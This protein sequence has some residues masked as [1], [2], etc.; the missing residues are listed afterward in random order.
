MTP[1][2]SLQHLSRSPIHTLRCYQLFV[3]T[4]T[5][6]LVEG[7]TWGS[8]LGSRTLQRAGCGGQRSGVKKG[9]PAR[10]DQDQR[11]DVT[12]QRL[13]VLAIAAVQIQ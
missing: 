3:H 6:T 12:W 1:Q 5:H 13:C 9:A 2:S 10:N 8:A 7:T 11:P 4:C